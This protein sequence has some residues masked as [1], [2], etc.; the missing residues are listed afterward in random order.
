M[1]HEEHPP[2]PEQDLRQSLEAYLV[3]RQEWVADAVGVFSPDRDR[4]H[5][6]LEVFPKP[7]PDK[8]RAEAPDPGLTPGQE[9]ALRAIAG[10]FGLGGEVDVASVTDYQINEGG[11]ARKID[12]EAR[13]NEGAKV[14][15]F[16]GLPIREIDE[17]EVAYLRE[18]LEPGV[19]PAKNEYELARQIAGWQEGFVALDEPEVLPYGYDVHNGHALLDEPTGQIV[20][21]GSQNGAEVLLLRVDRGPKKFD[22]AAMMGFISAML[23]AEG[24]EVSSVGINTS[25][26]Y[27]S[28]A[29]DIV[30]AGL[31]HGR[32]FRVG[33]YGRH[34]LAAVERKPAAEPTEIKQIPGEM[35]VIYEKLLELQEAIKQKWPS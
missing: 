26:T 5:D 23:S 31:Q 3:E 30:R 11:K 33:M 2:A 1:T 32:P 24:D 27:P 18:R 8:P 20:K 34:T 21:I 29:V 13:I 35:Y 17:D 10:R 6:P 12:A 4:S 14:I 9:T 15:I 28:R 22:T 16:A 19:E 7:D 25:T